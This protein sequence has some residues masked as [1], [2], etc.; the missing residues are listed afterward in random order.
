MSPL[1]ENATEQRLQAE[2]DTVPGDATIG[3]EFFLRLWRRMRG[4]EGAITLTVVANV[5]ALPA[6]ARPT[7]WF[8]VT[9]GPAADQTALFVGNGANQPLRRIPTS[10]L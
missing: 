10:P 1:D 4:L 8:R 5:A 2:A 7:E 6:N 3:P 9:G